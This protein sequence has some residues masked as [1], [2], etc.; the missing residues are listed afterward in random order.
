MYMLCERLIMLIAILKRRTLLVNH[1]IR[2]CL[3]FLLVKN[4]HHNNISLDG[5]IHVFTADK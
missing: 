1:F 3:P 2:G 4:L 5:A